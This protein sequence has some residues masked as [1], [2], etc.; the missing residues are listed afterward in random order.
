MSEDEKITLEK[1]LTKW[2][3]MLDRYFG[4][5]LEALNAII[6][7]SEFELKNRTDS[8]AK[9]LSDRLDTMNEFRDT[10][11]DQA[12]RFITRAD[13]EAFHSPVLISIRKLELDQK[14]MEGRVKSAAVIAGILSSLVVGLIVAI[15]THYI[16]K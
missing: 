7:K 9:Q 2:I 3:E 4:T 14:E 1:Y 5:K 8:T 11:K 16:T 13:V 10:L 6:A 12:A 15:I